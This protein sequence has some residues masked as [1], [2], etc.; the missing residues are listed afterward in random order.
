[1]NGW[2]LFPALLLSVGGASAA[3]DPSPASLRLQTRVSEVSN[4][5]HWVDNLAGTSVGKTTP[6][7]RRYWKQRFGVP[8]AGDREAL[9]AFVRI[10]RLR[11]GGGGK[12]GNRSGCLPI[13]ETELSWHQ[14][15][16][17][18]A[19]QADSLQDFLRRLTPHLEAADRAALEAAL[20]RFQERFAAVW[21]DLSHV[22]SFDARFR[23]FLDDGK[24]LGYLNSL[25]AF[26][27]V[28]SS[29]PGS[30]EPIRFCP[31]AHGGPARTPYPCDLESLFPLRPI[32]SRSGKRKG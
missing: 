12:L 14:V 32:E 16:L 23:E 6:L 15:F 27:D 1:V 31:L 30:K 11:I 17:A 18:E 3:A 21:R 26:L 13:V 19:M 2:L 25:A 28:L 29:R 10:R 24:L 7:Y 9:E 4:L 5:V 22:R 20:R 8:D